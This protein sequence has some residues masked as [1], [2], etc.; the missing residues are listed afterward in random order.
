MKKT[1]VYF[2]LVK[3]AIKVFFLLLF[4][5]S[6]AFADV[7]SCT[8]NI[9]WLGYS[10]KR[11]NAGIAKFL[12][13]SN[14]SLIL[15][16]EVVAPPTPIDVGTKVIKADNEVTEF[17]TQM[18]KHGYEYTLSNED[19]GT[20]DKIHNNSAST[21]WF[22]AFYKPSLLE[23]LDKGYLEEDRSNHQDYERVPYYFTFKEISSGMD[24][25]VIST[26]LKPGKSK[27]DTNRRYHELKSIFSWINTRKL[28]YKERDYIVLGD[29]NVYDCEKLDNNLE[30]G[31]KRAN[32][33][34]LNSN[35]KMNQPYD[36]VLYTDF[37]NIGSY[38]VLDMFELFDISRSTGNKEV[39]AK[40]SDHHPV[41]FTIVSEKDDD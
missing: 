1:N 19:T 16:Q 9:K 4:F 38:E 7:L 21:E 11:D 33:E 14:R 26:H 34:C 40:Y 23:L 36:Q 35:L 8:Y 25:S 2:I 17:F 12:S 13:D 39:I 27:K 30:N 29:M 3:K 6:S 22:V 20:G 10:K 37:S 15:I 24:F 28:T 31:F 32:T 18:S 41:F 5:Q